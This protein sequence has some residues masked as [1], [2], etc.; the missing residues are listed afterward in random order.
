MRKKC[1]CA[2]FRA[3]RV[4]CTTKLLE[5][6]QTINTERYKQQLIKVSDPIVQKRPFTSSETKKVMHGKKRK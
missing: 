1:Y 4:F 5:L 3:E 2:F 6:G